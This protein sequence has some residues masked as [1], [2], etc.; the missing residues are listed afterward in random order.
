VTGASS[1]IGRLLS[2]RLAREGARVALLA[3][4]ADAL[5]AV[6][7]EIRERG[8][9]AIVLPCDLS[10]SAAAAAAARRAQDQLGAVDL[11]VNNAGYGRHRPFLEWEL[12]DMDRM[13]HVNFLGALGMTRALAP[14]MAER[15]EGWIVFVSSVAGRIAPPE[16]SAYAASKFALVGLAEALSIELEDAGVHVLTVCPGAVRTPFFDAEALG[17]LPPVARR[18][19]VEPED[20]VEAVLR[21]LARGRRELTYPRSIAAAYVFRAL[22]PGFTRRQVKRV[23]L[24]ARRVPFS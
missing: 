8:G 18:S 3:R 17:R 4:R 9:E 19:M 14:G 13:L 16:E 20:L 21:A 10:D 12:E 24:G 1:G 11:L 5:E 15:G 6:A 23:T 22:A 2:L 7:A